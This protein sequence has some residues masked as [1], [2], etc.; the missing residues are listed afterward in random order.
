M[1]LLFPRS[2]TFDAAIRPHLD[3]LYRLA[4]RFTGSRGSAEDL[5][6]ELC[7]RMLPRIAEVARLDRPGP[8]LA[9]SLFNL[10]ID[11]ARRQAR[12]PVESVEQLPELEDPNPGPDELADLQMSVERIEAA[13]LELTPEQRAVI[14]WH[15]IEG[16]T[17]EE[18][19]EE[20]EVPLGTLKS[21]LHRAR[22]ALREALR[23]PFSGPGRVQE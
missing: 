12:Y 23:E 1:T 16:Y 9:R 6:Q 13:L 21:R 17:L 2:A 18:L 7:V 5:V 4:Y 8:W 3:R 20:H 19:A 22:A 10:Y 15:D 14:A 11:Q